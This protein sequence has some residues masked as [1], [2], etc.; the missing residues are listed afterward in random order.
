M[1]ND[2]EGIHQTL[3]VFAIAIAT[4]LVVDLVGWVVEKLK[5]LYK[6]NFGKQ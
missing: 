5:Y 3:S 2:I 4:I 1:D 6:K